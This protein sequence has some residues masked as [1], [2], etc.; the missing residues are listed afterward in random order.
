MS[1]TTRSIYIIT[2]ELNKISGLDGIVADKMEELEQ[3]V[4]NMVSNILKHHSE[5]NL[6]DYCGDSPIEYP[7][8][9]DASLRLSDIEYAIQCVQEDGLRVGVKDGKLF[10]ENPAKTSI[11]KDY[12]DQSAYA[13]IPIFLVYKRFTL[14]LR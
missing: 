9:Y 13:E 7:E 12:M 5:A 11:S 3:Q 2:K 6:F 14:S 8:K 1:R 4:K 10:V